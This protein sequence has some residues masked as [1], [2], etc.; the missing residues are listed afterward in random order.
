MNHSTIKQVN[1]N[2]KKQK[3]Q[4][5]NPGAD[6]WWLNFFCFCFVCGRFSVEKSKPLFF[7][8]TFFDIDTMVVGWLV[9]CYNFWIKQR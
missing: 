8:A 6:W 5:K 9:G 1:R 2:E 7:F 4:S 3:A